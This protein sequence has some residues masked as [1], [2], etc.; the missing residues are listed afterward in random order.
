MDVIVQ[1]TNLDGVALKV[2][3]DTRHIRV[4]INPDFFRMQERPP[5]FRRE[6]GVHNKVRKG[7]RHWI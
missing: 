4:D 5:I 2:L 6:D 1:S 3:Q 7:L